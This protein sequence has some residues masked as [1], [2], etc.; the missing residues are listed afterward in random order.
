[1][2][3]SIGAQGA[4]GDQGF[5]GDK[6]D[7]GDQGTVGAQGSIGVKGDQGAKGDQGNQ[8]IKG[9]MGN[10]AGNALVYEYE[11]FGDGQLATNSSQYSTLTNIGISRT[12]KIPYTETN[13]AIGNATS[14][15]AGIVAGTILRISNVHETGGYGLYTVSNAYDITLGDGKTYRSCNLVLISS[16]GNLNNSVEGSLVTIGYVNNGEAGTQG[17]QGTQGR[18]GSQGTGAQGVQ[19][20]QGTQ[21][22]Q[23]LTG[24][25]GGAAF[26][27]TFSTNT[28]NTIPGN[29]KLKFNNLTLSS[30]T[31]LYIS[32]I[33]DASVSVYNYL[34]TVD[35]STSAI[36]GHFTITEK[37]STTNFA[38]FAITGAVTAKSNGKL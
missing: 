1:M 11:T 33:D 8:G 7:K 30:A 21:G 28:S 24:N 16:Y 34:Q 37:G 17:T 32:E 10:P 20:P 29:G 22:P 19:G 23:G 14:W 38:L 2:Q 31:E 12:S 35:D 18:Q 13:Q 4:K 36:K 3:G 15:T 6:G 9:P 25:F 26:D 27:Y 5:K